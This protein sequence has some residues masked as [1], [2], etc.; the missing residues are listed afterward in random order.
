[1]KKIKALAVLMAVLMTV[2]VV[3]V[4]AQSVTASV[5]EEEAVGFTGETYYDDFYDATGH[6]E[7]WANYTIRQE[8]NYCKDNEVFTGNTYGVHTLTYTAP[9]DLE[10]VSFK[11]T[12]YHEDEGVTLTDYTTFTPMECKTAENDVWMLKGSF[13]NT[14]PVTVKKGDPL[15]TADIKIDVEYCGFNESTGVNIVVY[16][17]IDELKVKTADGYKVIIGDEDETDPVDVTTLPEETTDPMIATTSPA[18]PTDPAG[19]VIIGDANNDGAVDTL[20]AVLVQK[21]AGEKIRL[22]DEQI[23]IADVNNDGNADTLDAVL[24][25]EFAAGLITEFPDKA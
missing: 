3:T 4:C 6:C 16:L 12:L 13:A 24:I 11:F 21:H 18:A 8:S 19:T 23:Y 2:A 14:S 9:E 25:Q 20:D 22:T 1:M 15:L 10:I 17:S 7:D 5:T